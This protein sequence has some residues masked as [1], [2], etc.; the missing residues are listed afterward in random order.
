[1][2]AYTHFIVKATKN[3]PAVCD[4]EC[5]KPGNSCWQ[6]AAI[7]TESVHN[8]SPSERNNSTDHPPNLALKY[9]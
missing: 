7:K 6:T 3:Y 8:D 4:K 1:M 5:R 2:W 9:Y